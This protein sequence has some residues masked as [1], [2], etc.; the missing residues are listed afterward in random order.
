M[1]W[2]ELRSVGKTSRAQSGTTTSIGLIKGGVRQ[3]L[4]SESG[5]CYLIK[6]MNVH[7]RR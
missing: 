6:D 1:F 2:V 5:H 4:D 7:L 3:P